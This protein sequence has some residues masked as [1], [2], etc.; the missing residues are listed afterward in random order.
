MTKSTAAFIAIPAT[1]GFHGRPYSGNYADETTEAVV[2]AVGAWFKTTVPSRSRLDPDYVLEY[3]AFLRFAGEG[4]RRNTANRS[5]LKSDV[6][7]IVEMYLLNVDR[8]V[9][10]MVDHSAFL[11]RFRSV[12]GEPEVDGLV[13]DLLS[14]LREE[15]YTCENRESERSCL[16]DQ[17][18]ARANL[19]ARD[20]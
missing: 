4:L 18:T 20:V 6:I 17:A 9:A 1:V 19:C 15:V 16:F 13:K 10:L 14:L 12:L 7:V 11:E 5:L 2:A 3:E 8:I